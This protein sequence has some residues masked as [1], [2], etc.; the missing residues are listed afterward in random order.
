[1]HEDEDDI[2]LVFLKL[3]AQGPSNTS[4]AIDDV[5]FRVAQLEADDVEGSGQSTEAVMIQR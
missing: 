2:E 3:C 4:F 1:M 5:M